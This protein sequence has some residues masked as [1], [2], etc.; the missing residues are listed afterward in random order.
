[1]EMGQGPLCYNRVANHESFMV[2]VQK[3][4]T[5]AVASQDAVALLLYSGA[6]VWGYLNG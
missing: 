3:K 5:D 4:N 2:I 6:H 1:M